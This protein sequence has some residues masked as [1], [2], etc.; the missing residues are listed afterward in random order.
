MK[1][2]GLILT[3]AFVISLMLGCFG[4]DNT[5]S[6]LCSNAI[7]KANQCQPELQTYVNNQNGE[8]ASLNL[9]VQSTCEENDKLSSLSETEIIATN[10]SINAMDC[11]DFATYFGQLFN[12]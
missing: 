3:I 1:T 4:D 11:D 10:A 7:A 9:P 6:D 8:G 12:L 2:T 5:V